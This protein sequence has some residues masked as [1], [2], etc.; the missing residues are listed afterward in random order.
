MFEYP[1][2]S[3]EYIPPGEPPMK[4]PEAFHTGLT[5]MNKFL[6][7]PAQVSGETTN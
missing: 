7:T 2:N 5:D 6:E 4:D 1:I 3:H